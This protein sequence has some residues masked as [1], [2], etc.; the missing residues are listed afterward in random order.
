MALTVFVFGDH[1][2][3]VLRGGGSVMFCYL[4][5]R[6]FCICR[7]S[8][9]FYTMSLSDQHPYALFVTG[10]LRSPPLAKSRIDVGDNANTYLASADVVSF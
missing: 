9:P 8:I 5:W 1:L 10:G 6:G 3:V 2:T 7:F 4:K